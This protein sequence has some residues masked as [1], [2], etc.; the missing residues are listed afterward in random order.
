MTDALRG[1][2]L[3]AGSCRVVCVGVPE[4]L[5]TFG[6]PVARIDVETW[7][8]DGAATVIAEIVSW[9]RGGGVRIASSRLD[10]Q[11]LSTSIALESI[12]F[13][14]VEMILRPRLATEPWRNA[15][16]GSI[17]IRAAARNDLDA[18]RVIAG[19]AFDT[20]RY[21]LDPRLSA[22]ASGDRYADWVERALDSDRQEVW[23]GDEDGS[24][25]GL[26]VTEARDDGMYWHLTG[27]APTHQGRGLGPRLWK[28][29]LRRHANAGLSTV[30]TRISAHNYRVL[31]LYAALGAR[32]DA[33]EMTFHWVADSVD[34]RVGP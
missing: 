18:L 31:D 1:R 3:E 6:F 19:S 8:D 15:D 33:P 29:M 27:I 34:D 13:R 28:G 16:L 24:I 25:A 14:F 32:F 20:G 22:R 11:R 4:D 26:F 17:V 7:G 5:S 2:V 21:A 12:G 23:V 10:H 9:L 30:R